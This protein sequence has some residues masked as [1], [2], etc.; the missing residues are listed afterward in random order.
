MSEPKNHII[1]AAESFLRSLPVQGTA[2]RAIGKRAAAQWER[3][4]IELLALLGCAR[5]DSDR[6]F[7]D[8]ESV[9]VADLAAVRE[10][11]PRVFS[12]VVQDDSMSATTMSLLSGMGDFRCWQSLTTSY[13]GALMLAN[14]LLRFVDT[15]SCFYLFDASVSGSV[16]TV[17]NEWLRPDVPWEHVPSREDVCGKMF[18]AAWCDL[19]LPPTDMASA[20]TP[21]NTWFSSTVGRD[22]PPFLAGLCREQDAALAQGPG[23]LPILGMSM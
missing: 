7:W 6:K 19:V 13:N 11:L 1:L 20:R 16:L 23:E 12:V 3:E 4:R 10:C 5:V 2:K 21:I 9:E 15:Y 8:T 14:A 18:N 22:M 17:L